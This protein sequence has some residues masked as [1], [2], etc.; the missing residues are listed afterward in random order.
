MRLAVPSMAMIEGVFAEV[1]VS[2]ACEFPGGSGSGLAGRS[3]SNGVCNSGY[4][5]QHV[6]VVVKVCHSFEKHW[7]A[8]TIQ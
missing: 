8:N 2:T 7:Q 4:M 3:L 6:R 5:P 1:I